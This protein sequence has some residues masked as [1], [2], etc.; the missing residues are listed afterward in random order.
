MDPVYDTAYYEDL[1][2]LW[3]PAVANYLQ[4]FTS[5]L[6]NYLP[7]VDP[8]FPDAPPPASEPADVSSGARMIPANLRSSGG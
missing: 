2:D 8:T 4:R 1:A 7:A 5:A 6:T 3:I